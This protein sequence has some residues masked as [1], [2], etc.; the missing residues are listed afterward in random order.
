MT[1]D[2]FV[3]MVILVHEPSHGQGFRIVLA[4]YSSGLIL[5]PLQ[6]RQENGHQNGNHRDDNQQL[7]KGKSSS[8]HSILPFRPKASQEDQPKATLHSNL[9]PE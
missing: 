6:S 9:L 8:I 4:E 3:V 2:Q 7:D 5:G 1:T